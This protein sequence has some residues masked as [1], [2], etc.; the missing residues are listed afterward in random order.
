MP[1]RILVI[2]EG[3]ADEVKFLRSLFQNCYKKADYKVYSYKTNIHVLAQEL[4]NNYPDFDED[5]TDIKLVLASLETNADKKKKLLEKYTDV[6]MIFDFDPQHDHP[7][8]DTVRRMLKY[9]D[10]ST[11][12][13]KLFINYPMM[14]SYKHFSML[15][16]DSFADRKVTMEEI[17]NYKELVGNESNFTDLN[18]YT[19]LTFYSLAVHH[20]KKANKI[21]TGDYLLPEI[22]EYLDFDATNVYDKQLAILKSEEK[23]YVLNTCI[24]ALVD[25]A[26]RR[27]YG[28]LKQHATDLDI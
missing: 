15:P 24:F 13:G 26:P 1:K 16:D 9:F 22:R 25:F 4:Y 23:V 11:A 2:V 18:K 5:E 27:F 8:F 10:D 21:L 7:H 20:L 17:K 19:Y 14:Q 6:F 12:Q 3:E 28:F